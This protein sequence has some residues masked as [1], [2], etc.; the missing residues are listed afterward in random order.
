MFPNFANFALHLCVHLRPISACSQSEFIVY[1]QHVKGDEI[2]GVTQGTRRGRRTVCSRAKLLKDMYGNRHNTVDGSCRCH[3]STGLPLKPCDS[4]RA[5]EPDRSWHLPDDPW[6]IHLCPWR[7]TDF[8]PVPFLRPIR[9]NINID[10]IFLGYDKALVGLATVCCLEDVPS[11]FSIKLWIFDIVDVFLLK[12]L[13]KKSCT[14]L[15]ILT[16]H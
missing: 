10:E 11:W 3:L 14:F 16:R 13:K 8:R 9:C 2:V 12:I 4:I 7:H 15:K 1:R 5:T 6:Q